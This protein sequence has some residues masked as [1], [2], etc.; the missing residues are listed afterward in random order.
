MSIKAKPLQSESRRL[1]IKASAVTGAALASPALVRAA[2]K[3][4]TLVSWGG[5]YHDAVKRAIADPFT[6]ETGIQVNMFDTADLAKL[7]AQVMT[8]NVQWD[9]FDAP[10]A[11][12]VAGVNAG[13]WETLDP[14]M[15]DRK[16]LI[17]DVQNNLVPWY[18]FVG[19]IAWNPKK[20]GGK[21]PQNFKEY[22]DP[23]AF[24]GKRTF[25]SRPSETFEMALL[26]DGVDPAKLY[27]LDIDRAFRVLDR[28]KPHVAKWIESTPQT[29]TLLD[30]GETD[31][32]YTYSARVKPAKLSGGAVDFSFQQTMAGFEYLAVVKNTPN[33]DAAYK[34]IAFA[35]RPDRQAA[36]QE[37]LGYTPSSRK[38]LA[39]MNPESRKWIP[40]IGSNGNTLVNDAWWTQN[41]D[42]VGLRFKEWIM[43]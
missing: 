37:L 4:M 41:F 14:N 15:F 25:R 1:F 43:S 31:Y 19:G 16:D 21:H 34:F 22:F 6:A 40:E 2:S 33:R 30:A 24:P 11:L 7:R 42:A 27:P 39:L 13:L 20:L 38:A 17:V 8:N 23:V 26:A 5:T 28:I 18:V 29:L 3:S 35:T 36:L 9:V 10:S 32:T 12:G